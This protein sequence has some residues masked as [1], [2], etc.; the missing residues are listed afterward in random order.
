M[1]KRK[2]RILSSFGINEKLYVSTCF[3]FGEYD[4]TCRVGL[5]KKNYDGITALNKKR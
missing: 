3:I 5:L 1:A 4:K 2:Y